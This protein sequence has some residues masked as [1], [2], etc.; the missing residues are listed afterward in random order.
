MD[1]PEHEKQITKPS[2]K[3]RRMPET[4]PERSWVMSRVGHKDTKPEMIVRRLVHGMGYRYRLHR[5]NLP[6][7]P[8]LVFPSRKKVVFVHGCFWHAHADQHCK[9]SRPPKTRLDYWEPKLARNKERDSATEQKLKL[10]G[11][12]V[13]VVWECQLRDRDAL[14]SRLREFL[15]HCPQ[16]SEFV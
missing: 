1:Q 3:R 10:E 2:A 8:D 5:K 13:L 7:S 11:W 15:D 6:G 16:E 12:G 4:S 9:L 14:E